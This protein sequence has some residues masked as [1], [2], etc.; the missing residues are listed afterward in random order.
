MVDMDHVGYLVKEIKKDINTPYL[1]HN[2]EVADELLPVIQK[3]IP[4]IWVIRYDIRQ[5][6]VVTTQAKRKVI[7][8]LNQEID[9][10]RRK[11]SELSKVVESLSQNKFDKCR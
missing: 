4:G 8:Q 11:A 7:K 9:E 2:E 10:Y 5:W 1:I 6:F 3:Q